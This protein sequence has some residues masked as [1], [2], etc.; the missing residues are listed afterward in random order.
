MTDIPVLETE[1]L[2]LRGHR[3]SD[4]ELFVA[5]MADDAFA[6]H[7]TR[8]G[9]GLDPYEAWRST[10]V[11]AGSWSLDGFGNWVAELKATGE[12]IGR[13]GPYA[14][15]GWPGFEVGW[16]IF[17]AYQRRGY[18]REGAAAA[19]IWCH[20][21]LGKDPI[22]HC[23]HEGNLASEAVAKSLGAELVGDLPPSAIGP[24][25]LWQTPWERFVES[26]PYTRHVAAC[27]EKP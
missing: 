18:A 11:M 3:P 1:R 4:T 10:S 27:G 23:I 15:P 17:P 22:Y 16:A 25:R 7:I 26:D 20:E 14:P 9:R 6:R 2:I 8:E 21:A 19:M 12:V 13:V 24:V 5:A